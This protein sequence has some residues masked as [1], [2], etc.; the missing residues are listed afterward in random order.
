MCARDV[1]ACVREFE[2]D[3]SSKNGGFGDEVL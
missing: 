3:E 2:F 1:V